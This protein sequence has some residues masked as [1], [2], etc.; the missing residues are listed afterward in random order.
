MS[1]SSSTYY[2][3]LELSFLIVPVLTRPDENQPFLHGKAPLEL[4]QALVIHFP[5]HSCVSL[6]VEVT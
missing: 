3:P 2:T 4:C 5:D 6:A 1:L